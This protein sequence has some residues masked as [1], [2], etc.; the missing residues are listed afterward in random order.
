MRLPSVQQIWQEARRTF[1]RFPLVILNAAVGT[2]AAVLLIEPN[3]SI[4]ANPFV[5]IL[6]ATLLGIP[7]L[8]GVA[9]LVEKKRWNRVAGIGWQLFSIAL[10]IAYGCAAP[11]TLEAPAMHVIRLVLL[12]VALHLFVA[13]APFS[14]SKELNGFWQFNKT[15]LYRIITSG[16]Y[17]GVLFVGMAIAL[18]ALDQLF[19]VNIPPHRYAEL[20]VIMAGLFNTLVFLAGLPENLDDLEQETDY[21]KS[22]KVLVQY[23][24][25]PLVAIYLIILYAYVTKI[26][27]QWEWPKGWVSKL[28]LGFSATGI[29][30]LLLLYPLQDLKEFKWVRL[31]WH[32]FFVVLIP[33]IIMLP[34]AVWRRISEYG[35]TEGRYLAIVLALVLAMLAVYFIASK[36]KNIKVIPAL[37]GLFAL[38]VSYGPWSVFSVSESSQISRLRILLTT[39]NI[40]VD[41]KI[42]KSGKV[43]ANADVAQI[44]SIISY[45]HEMH[46]YG[47][48][49]PWFTEKLGNDSTSVSR[50]KYPSDVV[51]LMGIQYMHGKSRQAEDTFV[52]IGNSSSVINISG[53]DHMLAG[54]FVSA[55][56]TKKE[57]NEYPLIYSAN[58]DMDVVTIEVR[59][60]NLPPASLSIDLQP[61]FEKLQRNYGSADPE[62][63][64]L[65]EMSIAAADKNLSVKL[66]VRRLRLD[67]KGDGLKPQNYTLDILYSVKNKREQ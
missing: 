51:A 60:A 1:L 16:F 37:L 32:W 47:G 8:T 20:W 9:L 56:D 15:L 49:Q 54:Q 36:T 7:L 29:L 61:L 39:N 67:A 28:I 4:T 43:V 38:L 41:G 21:P 25:T 26:I 66:Y 65:E 58:E 48:I 50:R 19:G 12:G 46:G 62:S 3:H 23:I 5:N 11:S 34:L 31:A 24:L 13:V 17:S 53:Y 10:L 45:L 40:L 52:F 63:I 27:V 14:G 57:M 30:S 55:G 44:S 6:Y 42:R 33:V 18:V 35:V 2:G 64:P 59:P 22:L